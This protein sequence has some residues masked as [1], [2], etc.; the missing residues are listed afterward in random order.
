MYHSIVKQTAKRAFEAV[1]D[2]DYEA[3]ISLCREDV[4]HRFG[5]D[6]ALGGIRRDKTALKRWFERLGRVMPTLKLTIRDIWVKGGPWNTVV[7]V[8][9][10]A[11][12]APEDGETYKN[13]GVHIIQMQWGKVSSI[14]ANEDS[15]AVASVLRRQAAAGIDEALAGP[16]V[17]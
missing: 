5:G 3:L 6:H 9:W 12:G 15:Q 13:H 4:F 8:R 17:S 1:N 10:E 7:I 11:I 14:D 16:I 2:H